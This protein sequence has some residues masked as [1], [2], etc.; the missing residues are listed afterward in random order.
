MQKNGE[1]KH[2]QQNYPLSI[3]S[4]LAFISTKTE[5]ESKSETESEMGWKS[6]GRLTSFA[7][8][9]TR[10]GGLICAWTGWRV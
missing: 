10:W 5:T 2:W 7:L 3:S 1:K 8:G 4:L 6:C 9:I